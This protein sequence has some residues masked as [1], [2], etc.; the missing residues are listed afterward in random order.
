MYC[1]RSAARDMVPAQ[2]AG[3]W[4]LNPADQKEML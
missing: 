2:R 3:D 4:A 1:P